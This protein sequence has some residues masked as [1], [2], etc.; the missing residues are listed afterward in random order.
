MHGDVP[1]EVSERRDAVLIEL[2]VAASGSYASGPFTAMSD[3]TIQAASFVSDSLDQRCR[4]R[5]SSVGR[6]SL[7]K[8]I[9]SSSA[10]S[11]SPG[12][13]SAA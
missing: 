3:G 7:L 6:P 9:I 2:C 5:N 1:T 13:S 4:M 10:I 12:I 11:S 8:R